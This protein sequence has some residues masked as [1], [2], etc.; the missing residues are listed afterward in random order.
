ME[1]TT[2]LFDF[3]GVLVDSMP[4]WAGV[5]VALLKEHGVP[6]P[7]DI[8]KQITPLGNVGASDFC[9]ALGLPMTREEVLEHNARIYTQKYFY[10]IPA[11][12]D[13]LHT[14]QTLKSRGASLH[15]LTASPHRYVDPCL[16]RNGLYDLFDNVW[17]IDDFGHKKDEM[18][19]Y[20]LAAKRLGKSPTECTFL[21]DNFIAATT[22]KAAGMFSVGV[23]D[24]SAADMAEQMKAHCDRYI[25]DF[26]ELVE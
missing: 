3:D 2:Y 10:E 9:I 5:Y 7:E 22:A 25:Y 26:S 21:D 6:Y 17:T 11:K 12:K 15:V 23:F 20:E 18:I 4:T 14:L 16:K 13:V 19:I 8:V 24:A 1:N